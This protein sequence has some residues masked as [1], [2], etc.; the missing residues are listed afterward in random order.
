[1][2]REQFLFLVAIDAFKRSNAKQYPTWSDVLE[3]VRLLGYRKTMP[4]ELNLPN[5]EDWRE[6]SNAPSNVRPERW[7]E[8]GRRQA[9]MDA[10]DEFD[11]NFGQAA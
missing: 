11:Q 4:S 10:L 6:P 9:Q 7:E 1:M 3:V 2:N 5:A 8:R